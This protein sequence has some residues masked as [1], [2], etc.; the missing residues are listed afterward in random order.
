MGIVGGAI[1][2]RSF[3]PAGAAILADAVVGGAV[4]GTIGHFA[5]G[6]SRKELKELG[7]LLDEGEAAV[8][9]VAQDA[10]ATDVDKALG[11]AAKRASAKIDD[12]DVAA[13]AEIEKGADKATVK[14][15]ADLS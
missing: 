6:L 4:L 15:A 8:I 10:V 7:N 2:G 11:K 1:V 3:P 13:L 14:A 12:G 5:G 9:A